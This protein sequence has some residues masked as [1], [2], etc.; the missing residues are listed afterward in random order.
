MIQPIQATFSGYAGTPCSLFSAYD[1]DS[2][3]LVVAAQ[4]EYHTERRNDCLILTNVPELDRDALFTMSDIP[5]AI[6]AYFALKS[7]VAANGKKT[8]LEFR[9]RAERANP[10]AAIEPDG[11]TESGPRY[12]LSE[13]ITCAQMAALATCRYAIRANVIEDAL[14]MAREYEDLIDRVMAG[15]IVTI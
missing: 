7:G 12:R 1:T 3:I 9:S 6:A 2:R 5:D 14:T 11:L 4:S 13:G 8:R 10:A 15:E